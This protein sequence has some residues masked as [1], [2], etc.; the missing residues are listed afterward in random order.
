MRPDYSIWI[1]IHTVVP[2]IHFFACDTYFKKCILQCPGYP[3]CTRPKFIMRNSYCSATDTHF[4]R[5]PSI[6]WEMHTSVPRIHILYAA[7]LYRIHHTVNEA[8]TNFLT[9]KVNFMRDATWSMNRISLFVFICG[10]AY[11]WIH[12]LSGFN[13]PVL[14]TSW[15]L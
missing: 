13:I 7:R 11:P 4:V 3:F 6:L 15:A 2:W 9:I 14:K 1:E 8:V 12:F 5:G 10:S